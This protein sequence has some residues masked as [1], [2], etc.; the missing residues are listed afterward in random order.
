MSGIRG[1]SPTDKDSAQA[2]LAFTVEIPDRQ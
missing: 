2:E 1:I